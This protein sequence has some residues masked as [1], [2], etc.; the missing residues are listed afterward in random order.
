MHNIPSIL[1]SV[2]ASPLNIN[3]YT[4]AITIPK[5][6]KGAYIDACN[7]DMEKN[8]SKYP[9]RPMKILITRDTDKLLVSVIFIISWKYITLYAIAPNK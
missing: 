1:V 8:R 6:D 9:K 4:D 7:L 2:M 5:Y 3:P